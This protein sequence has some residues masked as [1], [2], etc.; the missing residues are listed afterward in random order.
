MSTNEIL[1][2]EI[3]R[4]KKERN[5]LILAHNYKWKRCRISPILWA[6]PSFK[7]KVRRGHRRVIFLRRPLYGESAAI[8]APDKNVLLPAADAGCPLADF[9]DAEQV[10]QWRA[11]HP[12]AAVVAYINSS[13]EVKAKQIF[14]AP[15]PTPSR[16]WSPYP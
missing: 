15:P 4:L 9:A 3:T 8:L 1:L 5:A 10:R 13:A 16:W 14:V 7:S 2:A 12:Q 6:I 11:R